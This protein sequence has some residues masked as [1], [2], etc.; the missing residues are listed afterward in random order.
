[1]VFDDNQ[2]IETFKKNEIVAIK[3]DWTKRDKEIT[4]LLSQYNSI[5]VPLYVLIMNGKTKILPSMLTRKNLIEAIE[6]KDE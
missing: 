3:C 6:G 5:S 1:M 2:V 4:T